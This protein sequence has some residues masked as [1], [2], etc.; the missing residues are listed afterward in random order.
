MSAE[1]V[2]K[3]DA[4]KYW[5]ERYK[6]IDIS[7]SGH[8][9][10]PV[11][12]NQWL[13]RRKKERLLQGLVKAGF[14][15]KGASVLEIAAGTGVYVE[16]WKSLGVGKLCGMDISQNAIDALSVRFPG[17]SFHKRDLTD[18]GLSSLTGGGYDLVTAVDMLYH[19]VDDGDF[20]AALANLAETCRPGGL[21]AIHDFFMHHREM[22]FGYIKLRTLKDYQAALA[23]AGFEIVS[24]TPTFFFTVQTYDH[25]SPDTKKAMDRLWSRL[26][27]PFI[28]GRPDLAGRL[29]YY[30]DKIL[31]SLLKEGPSFEMMVCRRKA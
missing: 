22:D 18:P 9:D 5:A 13:Y 2:R 6:E 12:Y 28:N 8:I 23:K 11:A 17:Y 15:P 21:L 4:E 1:T 20:P 10:L 16:M 26:V 24:R 19:I 30:S 14:D 27:F 25:K 31:G 3:Y 29:G 7:K